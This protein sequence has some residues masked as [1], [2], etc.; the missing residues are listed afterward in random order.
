MSIYESLL[1]SPTARRTNVTGPGS[2]VLVQ[3]REERNRAMSHQANACRRLVLLWLEI[4]LYR[5]RATANFEY[6]RISVEDETLRYR[7]V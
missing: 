2:H 1:S 6:Y 3:A 5:I 7:F 4:S